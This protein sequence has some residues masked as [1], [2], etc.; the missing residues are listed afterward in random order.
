MK[1]SRILWIISVA[2][3]W[4]TIMALGASESLADRIGDNN[5]IHVGQGGNGNTTTTGDCSNIGSGTVSD[6]CISTTTTG[7]GTTGGGTTGKTK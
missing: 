2:I 6:S 5:N 4:A 1:R 3:L 7:P